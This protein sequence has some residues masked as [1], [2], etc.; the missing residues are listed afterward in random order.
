MWCVGAKY[1]VGAAT[2]IELMHI[3]KRNHLICS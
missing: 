3:N 2:H 1:L